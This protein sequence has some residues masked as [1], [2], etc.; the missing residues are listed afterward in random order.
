[1]KTPEKLGVGRFYSVE[2]DGEGVRTK[3]P[4][5]RSK[6]DWALDKLTPARN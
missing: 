6:R 3:T 4:S 2:E 5:S 1:M